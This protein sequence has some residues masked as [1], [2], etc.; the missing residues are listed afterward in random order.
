MKNKSKKTSNAQMIANSIREECNQIM[1]MLLEK[2]KCYG[3]SA[4]EPLRI[5]SKVDTTEQIF[6]R[7]DDKL[8]R[9]SRGS[10]YGND[11]TVLDLI[12]YLVLLRVH[13]RMSKD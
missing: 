3:N 10:E 5:F 6:V 8:S 12:G 9:I 2:N 1:D 13:T 7:I 4:F 11:D